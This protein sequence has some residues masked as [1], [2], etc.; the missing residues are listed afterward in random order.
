MVL[1]EIA[2]QCDLRNSVNARL[3]A[4]AQACR[5]VAEAHLSWKRDVDILD[6]G[7]PSPDSLASL[8]F[9]DCAH[10]CDEIANW[11]DY[12]LVRAVCP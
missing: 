4:Q 8:R 6:S 10:E 3:R 9:Q 7:V 5:R 2:N 12:H 11:K 1:P